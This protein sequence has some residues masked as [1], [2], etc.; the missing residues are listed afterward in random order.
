[1]VGAVNF[2]K[3]YIGDYLR[4]TGTLTLAQH[5]AYMLMLLEF[6]ATE[7]PLPTGRRLRLVRGMRTWV[8][9]G[10]A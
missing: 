5:G 1:M 10:C 8:C 3:L 9:G 4:D 7:R 6:Y 2:A